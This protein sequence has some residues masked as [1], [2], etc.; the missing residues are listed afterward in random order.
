[1]RKEEG[2]GDVVS[3]GERPIHQSDTPG[4]SDMIDISV[5]RGLAWRKSPQFR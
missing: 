4:G 1:M 5:P 2:K 3:G